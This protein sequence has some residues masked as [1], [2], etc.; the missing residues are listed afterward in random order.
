MS[1]RKPFIL[2]FNYLFHPRGGVQNPDNK[3]NTRR[4]EKLILTWCFP[5]RGEGMFSAVSC[6]SPQWAAQR[7]HSTWRHQLEKL[8][9]L[10]ARLDS[11]LQTV[12]SSPCLKCIHWPS[13][14]PLIKQLTKCSS[15]ATLCFLFQKEMRLVF[16]IICGNWSQS[17][18]TASCTYWTCILRASFARWSA[19]GDTAV[20]VTVPVLTQL[21]I[22]LGCQITSHGHLLL[23]ASNGIISEEI[24]ST[25][26][27]AMI[28]QRICIA[29]LSDTLLPEQSS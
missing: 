26:T 23:F 12:V 22:Y 5:S 1:G 21:A 15:S 10:L 20:N 7:E 16:P 11:I 4:L 3:I 9:D 13:L 27:R 29:F 24:L 25:W 28:V 2:K 14:L 6:M 19:V 18:T 8:K 17:I